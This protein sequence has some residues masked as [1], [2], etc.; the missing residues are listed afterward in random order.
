MLKK[1][2]IL[3]VMPVLFG[4]TIVCSLGNSGVSEAEIQ[5]SLPTAAVEVT[6]EVGEVIEEQLIVASL[7][8][9]PTPEPTEVV[10]GALTAQE[11]YDLALA[12]AQT[13]QA[14]A[15]LVSLGT[16]QLGPLDAEGKSESWSLGFYSPSAR[17]MLT[18]SFI[19]GS[20]NTPPA[21]QLPTDP[22]AIPAMDSVILEMKSIYDT[23]A[24]EA[25]SKYTGEAYYVIAGLTP[26]PLDE[27]IPTWYIHYHDAQ[28]NTV[29]FTV[30]IDAR[31]GEVIQSIDIAGAG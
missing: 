9:T 30:I 6:E 31:S 4:S 20:L 12:E 10:L 25:G 5:A 23:A 28:N 18:L 21:V 7:V 29:S 8:P 13:W 27:S 2:F 17:E 22:G 14:D 16:T 1:T 11:A 3:L 24:A 15:T 26:Y 19:N